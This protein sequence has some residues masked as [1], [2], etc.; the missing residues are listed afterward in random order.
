M[1]PLELDRQNPTESLVTPDRVVPAYD[2]FE[3]GHA[4]FSLRPEAPTIDQFAI[5]RHKEPRHVGGV[6][7]VARAVH[8]EH[9]A[10]RTL[11]RLVAIG[12]GLDAAVGVEEQ[13]GL[14]GAQRDRA[15]TQW[16]IGSA[17]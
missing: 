9:D 8:A 7:A 1:T 6:L 15:H 10:A 3:H 4:G 2:E 17:A 16:V 14:G 12:C 13:R 5:A 11:K